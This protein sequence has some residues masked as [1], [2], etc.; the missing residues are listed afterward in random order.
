ME[1]CSVLVLLDLSLAYDT[2]IMI[3]FLNGLS[4]VVGI[5][6]T[7]VDWFSSYL[8]AALSCGVPQG[9]V[10]APMLFS[11]HMLLLGQIT[12]KYLSSFSTAD[13]QLYFSFNPSEND[14]PFYLSIFLY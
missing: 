3:I 7:T 9:S 14:C 8:A 4:E 1:K 13:I 11:L 12:I 5:S 10:L 6:G 2:L